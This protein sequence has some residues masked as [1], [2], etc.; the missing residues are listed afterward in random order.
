MKTGGPD[1][2]RRT[3][4]RLPSGEAMTESARSESFEVKALTGSGGVAAPSVHGRSLALAADR[5][6]P[7]PRRA[8]RVRRLIAP[9]ARS[10]PPRR[11][12]EL[13]LQSF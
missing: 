10:S 6:G 12:H 9:Q 3:L 13:K 7:L 4:R 11:G 8:V 5:L 2:A 1:P